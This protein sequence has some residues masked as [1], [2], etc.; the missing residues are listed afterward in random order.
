M[1]AMLNKSFICSSCALPKLW[2]LM[3]TGH[4]R[5][6]ASE[7]LSPSVQMSACS[8]PTSLVGDHTSVIALDSIQIDTSFPSHLELTNHHDFPAGAVS[9]R[10]TLT[11]LSCH[12]LGL[13]LKLPI[14]PTPGAPDLAL[15]VLHNCRFDDTITDQL[16]I[17]LRK[18]SKG[19]GISICSRRRDA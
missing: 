2:L 18:Y 5:R 11:P 3:G 6:G 10:T 17:T 13:K 8:S 7:E 16:G 15:A 19:G 4:C 1:S 14:V 9:S 12:I